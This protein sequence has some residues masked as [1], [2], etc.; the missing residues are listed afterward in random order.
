MP[1]LTK[2]VATDNGDYSCVEIATCDKAAITVTMS[3]PETSGYR[4]AGMHVK[5]D[6][7]Y[8]VARDVYICATVDELTLRY[9]REEDGLLGSPTTT[10]PPTSALGCQN[11]GGF[12]LH[13]N[14]AIARPAVRDDSSARRPVAGQKSQR[15]MRLFPFCLKRRQ[16]DINR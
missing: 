11:R 4:S 5:A 2:A 15:A 10:E 7:K 8:D 14:I 9:T 1:R 13:L 12:A 3:R 6:F 16:S